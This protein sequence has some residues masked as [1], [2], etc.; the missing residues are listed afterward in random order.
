MQSKNRKML[1]YTL[2]LNAQT[3][4]KLVSVVEAHTCISI[5]HEKVSEKNEAMKSENCLVV[6]KINA[7]EC[8]I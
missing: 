7:I 3:F 2:G 8:C 4:L 6:H 1:K 5:C